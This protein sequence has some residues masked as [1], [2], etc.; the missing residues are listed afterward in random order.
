MGTS[1]PLSYQNFFSWNSPIPKRFI[2]LTP[3]IDVDSK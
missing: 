2:P 1:K 3:G